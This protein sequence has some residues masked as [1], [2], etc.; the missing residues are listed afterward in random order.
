M[1]MFG[2]ILTALMVLLVVGGGT[3][4]AFRVGENVVASPVDTDEHEAA[5]DDSSRRD[6]ATRT[7]AATR[8]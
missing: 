4:L 7:S 8:H 1:T 5:N 6:S 2:L 3:Y